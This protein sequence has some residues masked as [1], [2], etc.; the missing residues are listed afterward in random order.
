MSGGCDRIWDVSVERR[1]YVSEGCGFSLGMRCC[2][3][4][5]CDEESED[6][7]YEK[8]GRYDVHVETNSEIWGRRRDRMYESR[9]PPLLEFVCAGPN[10]DDCAGFP[11]D[12]VAFPNI[13]VV[14]RALPK[15][16]PKPNDVVELG[17]V[18]EGEFDKLGVFEYGYA[19]RSF[20]ADCART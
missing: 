12:T 8:Y 13:L 7:M 19:S 3:E 15:P 20:L 10:M 1:M 16:D 17:G 6:G 9:M 2:D 5:G 11:K 4:E 18:G 14:G